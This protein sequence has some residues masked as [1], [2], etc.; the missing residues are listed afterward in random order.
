MKRFAAT[1]LLV[2]ASLSAFAQDSTAARLRWENNILRTRIDSLQ[3]ALDLAK[4]S[5]G[6]S[7]L[8]D[9]DAQEAF[10][11]F[12]LADAWDDLETVGDTYAVH[13][14]ISP[15]DTLLRVPHDGLY[16]KY[17]DIYSI[18]RRN[19]MIRILERYDRQRPMIEKT[20]ER[21]GV[22]ARLSYIAIVESAMQ[23]NA[24]SKAGAV[25]LWQLMPDAAREQGLVVS[26]TLDDRYDA[27]KSTA[28]AA[29][30]LAAAYRRYG[31]WPLAVMSYNCGPGR[32]DAAL[33]GCGRSGQP[34]LSEVTRLLPR[35]TRE[36]LPAIAAACYVS[37]NRET[38]FME[39]HREPPV[40]Q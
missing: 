17:L 26:F 3:R 39:F 5:G 32:L 31:D 40:T 24:K 12:S 34:E 29:R 27:E 1:T 10:Y 35:E 14:D 2:L 9:Y 6:L 13:S 7:S 37:E 25:G 16:Q 23:P 11:S 28:A 15:I 36:Y 20:F 18:I 30:I 8:D 19:N 33:R 22:P 21:Y 38:L 4:R